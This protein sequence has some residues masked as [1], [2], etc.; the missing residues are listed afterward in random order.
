VP[1]GPFGAGVLRVELGHH[2][3]VE[4]EVSCGIQFVAIE[5]PGRR[6][7][8]RLVNPLFAHFRDSVAVLFH[9]HA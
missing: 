8:S 3:L 5:P 9:L 6:A 7:Q 4:L 2:K 1:R